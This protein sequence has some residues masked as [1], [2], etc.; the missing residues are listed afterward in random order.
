M[1]SESHATSG[2]LAGKP[3]GCPQDPGTQGVKLCVLRAGA[4]R[5]LWPNLSVSWDGGEDGGWER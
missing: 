5:G 2:G 3:W 4:T 1:A